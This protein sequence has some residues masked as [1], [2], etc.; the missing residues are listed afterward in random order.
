MCGLGVGVQSPPPRSELL[1]GQQQPVI[2][3][4]DAANNDAVPEG[5]TED[6]D[7]GPRLWSGSYSAARKM[8]TQEEVEEENFHKYNDFFFKKNTFLFIYVKNNMMEKLK[9]KSVSFKTLLKEKFGNSRF[10][11]ILLFYVKL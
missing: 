10:K 5:I 4:T 8:W 3:D 2:D 7:G 9:N 11:N 1:V 6:L